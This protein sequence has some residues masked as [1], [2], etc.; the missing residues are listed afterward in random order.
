MVMGDDSCS[1]GRGFKSRHHILDGQDIF[2]TL[3]CCKNC[4]VRLKK[5]ENKI[6]EKRPGL[7]HFFKNYKTGKLFYNLAPA[8]I[9]FSYLE[10]SW[11]LNCH[12]LK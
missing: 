7:A 4:I 6:N 11:L 9:K 3:I 5:T 2:S 10:K 12:F 1:R 8:L